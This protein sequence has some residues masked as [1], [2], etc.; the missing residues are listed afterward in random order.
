M[1]W[2]RGDSLYF[3]AVESHGPEPLSGT[4]RYLL[5]HESLPAAPAATP[6]RR[7]RSTRPG[8]S[9]KTHTHKE[10]RPS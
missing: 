10:S 5:V 7:A 4:V 9:A 3:D 1:T 2:A 8:R 6:G